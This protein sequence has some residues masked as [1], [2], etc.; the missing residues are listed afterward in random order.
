MLLDLLEYVVTPCSWRARSVGFLTSSL[1]VQAR[2]R[3]C[4]RAWA[5][6]LVRTRGV[7]LEA[8]ARCTEKRLA[9][10]LGAGLLHDIP[11]RELSEM[12]REVVL[13]DVV[14]PWASRIRAARFQNVRCLAAEVTETAHALPL[15]ARD[16]RA[17]LPTSK[18]TLFLA[19]PSLDLTVSVNLLSQLPFIPTSYLRKRG[20]SEEALRVWSRHLQDAHL[21]WLRQLPGH[22]ALITDIG[23]QHR[24]HAGTVLESWDNLHGLELPTGGERWEWQIA[25]APEVDRNYDRVVEVAAYPEW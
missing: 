13:V 23:G 4:R 8:A 6:H 2:H 18:P 11:L 19:E 1:Q 24:D 20:F 22:I 17:P 25:P 9:V 10:I 5:P 15:A 3:R 21:A 14:F 7:I 12:F 16:L